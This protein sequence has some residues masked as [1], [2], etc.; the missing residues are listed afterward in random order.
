MNKRLTVHSLNLNI[1]YTI[2]A[3]GVLIS[4]KKH[5]FMRV[6]LHKIESWPFLI[7]YRI[8]CAGTFTAVEIFNRYLN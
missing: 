2:Y 6:F 4:R 3:E 7:D 5:Q 8:D 1:I